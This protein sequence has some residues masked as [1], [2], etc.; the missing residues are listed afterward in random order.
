MDYEAIKQRCLDG[1]RVRVSCSPDDV[2]EFEIR[3]LVVEVISIASM[4][5]G[6][7]WCMVS[8][9]QPGE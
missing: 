8:S 9:P 4:G 1:Y 7:R 3:G 2:E 6:N 5:N